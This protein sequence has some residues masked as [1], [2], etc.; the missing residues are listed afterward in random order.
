LWLAIC[1]AGTLAGCNGPEIHSAAQLPAEFRAVPRT[2]ANTLELSH[3]GKASVASDVIDPGD[4]VQFTICAG[5]SLEDTVSF[6]VRVDDQGNAVLPVMGPVALAGLELSDAEAAIRL[7]GIGQQL[8]RDPIVTIAI[9]TRRTRRVTVLGAV[10]HP[11]VYDLRA[12]SC[13]LPSAIAQAG[14][15]TEEADTQVEVRKTEIPIRV[16]PA[17]FP[18]DDASK[19]PPTAARQE[20]ETLPQATVRTVR[21]DLERMN[22]QDLE[23]PDGAVV[24][25]KRRRPEFVHVLGLVNRPNRFEIPATGGL[26]LMDAIAMAEGVAMP[27]ADKVHIVRQLPNQTEA[28]VIEASIRQ[29]MRNEQENLPLAAGDIIS[30]EQTNVTVLM[31]TVRGVHFDIGSTEH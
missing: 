30:V 19:Y 4:V 10:N 11:G 17:R 8:Y 16:E 14:G 31:E 23:L 24:M 20:K 7:A 21:I 6:P 2:T 27:V 9:K 13:D 18:T 5:L 26:R 28:I 15:L 29:A 1:A 25:V 12:R 22:T 3:L